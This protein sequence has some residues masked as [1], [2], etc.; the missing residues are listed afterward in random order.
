MPY[1]SSKRFDFY[2]FF[3]KLF[4]FLLWA[5][6]LCLW[7]HDE[8]FTSFEQS[9][10]LFIRM[11]LLQEDVL[12]NPILGESSWAEQLDGR[13]NDAAVLVQGLVGYDRRGDLDDDDRVEIRENRAIVNELADLE[14]GGRVQY[15]DGSLNAEIL[16]R[17]RGFI[18][19][20]EEDARGTLLEE[21]QIAM[22]RGMRF[23]NL[24]GALPGVLEQR[25]AFQNRVRALRSI[26]EVVNAYYHRWVLE[27]EVRVTE[28]PEVFAGGSMEDYVTASFFT[29]SNGCF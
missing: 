19:A 13:I 27:D 21:M 5:S 10:V 22:A 28:H 6:S 23:F 15:I 26:F 25:M 29:D 11:R 1:C 17:L 8:K 7:G 9:E 20:L 4:M 14:S 18:E 12:A 2:R 16:T 3:I 24:G